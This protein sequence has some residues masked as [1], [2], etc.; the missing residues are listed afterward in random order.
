MYSVLNCL[1]TEHDLRLVVV[2]GIICFLASLVA[3][4]LLR[5]AR[6]T[7]GQTRIIWILTAGLATGSGIW[8]THF[9]AMLAYDPG[10]GIHYNIGL[11]ALSLLAAAAITTLGLAVA[12]FAPM[13]RGVPIGGAILGAGVACMHYMGMWAIELLGRITWTHDLIFLSIALGMLLGVVALTIAE[14]RTDA[15]GTFAA[16]V[17]LTLAIV[18]HHFTAM[19]AIEIVP[20]PTRVISTFSFS[21]TSLAIAIAGV[22]RRAQHQSCEQLRGSPSARAQSPACRGARQHAAGPVHVRRSDPANHLQ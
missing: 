8:A 22:D 12:I 6:A 19:G 20:D 10:I 1:T 15:M 17:F 18:S 3:I 11:T 21:P 7:A 4:K 14:R 9:I 2:A 13:R 16:A 5:R